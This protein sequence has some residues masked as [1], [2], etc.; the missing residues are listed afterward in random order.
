MTGDFKRNLKTHPTWHLSTVGVVVMKLKDDDCGY[1][2]HPNNHHGAGKVLT[3]VQGVGGGRI[4]HLRVLTISTLCT[5]SVPPKNTKTHLTDTQRK[6]PT[7]QGNRVWS[8]RHNLCNHEHEDSQR[9]QNRDA[10]RQTQDTG[11][12]QVAEEKRMSTLSGTV[13]LVGCNWHLATLI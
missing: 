6:K 4:T 3:W 10:W 13:C 2:W 12:K 1:D 7:Y 11:E 8:C 5:M 9:E